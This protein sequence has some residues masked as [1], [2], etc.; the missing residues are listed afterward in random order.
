MLLMVLTFGSVP[1]LVLPSV[2]LEIG[3]LLLCVIFSKGNIEY[4]SKKSIR[5]LLYLSVFSI[6]SALFTSTG[7]HLYISAI[8][9]F[10]VVFLVFAFFKYDYETIHHYLIKSFYIIAYLSFINFLLYTF[11]PGIFTM[12]E[13]QS[14]YSI[15][16]FLMI[17]NCGEFSTLSFMR[18]QGPF[19]EPGILQIILNI[20][21][22][23]S[24]IDKKKI[25][26][27]LFIG[28]LI[29]STGSTTG[30]VL[31][32]LIVVYSVFTTKEKTRKATFYKI[33]IILAG[34]LILPY[35]TA[36]L[37]NKTSGESKK[38]AASRTYDMIMGY[39]IVKSSPFL[40]IGLDFDK[41]SKLTKNVNLGFYD[42]E[43]LSLDRGNTNTIISV[44]VFCGVPVAI[45]FVLGI[46]KQR[47]FKHR[48]LFFLIFFISLFSEPLF[49]VSFTFMIVLSSLD[50][51]YKRSPKFYNT[52]V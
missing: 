23:H 47:I 15:L 4:F 28:A 27:S 13:N 22:M 44:A 31:M 39:E 36:N 21:L 46:I 19:W 40:G 3:I 35:V 16:S 20:L 2:A 6:I 5:V 12:L 29:F 1:S 49:V 43:S 30:L 34:L 32:V 42:D 41:Y 9:R 25:V 51:K 38:S 52:F 45:L 18:N 33:A 8:F 50:F 37:T 24:L 11:V 14:G 26:E 10:F 17:F 48:F 7:P